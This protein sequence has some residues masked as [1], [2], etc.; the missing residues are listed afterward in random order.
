MRVGHTATHEEQRSG[1]FCLCKGNFIAGPALGVSQQLVLIHHK[2][3]GWETAGHNPA[4]SLQGRNH[5]GSIGLVTDIS[6]DQSDFPAPFF[7]FA[8]FIVGQSTGGHSVNS[9]PFETALNPLLKDKGFSCTGG[10]V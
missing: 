1:R 5:H 8:E 6:G 3:I 7:P 4:L 9:M 2:Q 10:S